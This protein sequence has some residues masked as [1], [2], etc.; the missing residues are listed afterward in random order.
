[1]AST[2]RAR[3]TVAAPRVR[4]TVRRPR[5]RK[6]DRVRIAHEAMSRVR[7]KAPIDFVKSVRGR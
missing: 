5:V 2:L 1:M 7:I 3:R 4:V 6:K